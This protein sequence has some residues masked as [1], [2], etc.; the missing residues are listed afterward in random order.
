M[1]EALN[2]KFNHINIQNFRSIKNIELDLDD[3]GIVIVKGINN[4]V[5]LMLI[6][7]DQVNL[8]Y[9]KQ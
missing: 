6:Q 8:Q 7:M 5:I 3:Q 1:E 9:F 4:I 2:I